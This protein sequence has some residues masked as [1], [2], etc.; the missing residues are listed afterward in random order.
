MTR[1]TTD[2]MTAR[3]AVLPTPE[4]VARKAA[5]LLAEAVSEGLAERGEASLALSGGRTPVPTLEALRRVELDW[6]RVYVTLV[7]ERWVT[8]CSPDSNQ[9]L[10]EEH[11]LVGRACAARFIPMKN[12]ALSPLAGIGRYVQRLHIMPR[13]LDAVLLGMGEDGHFASLFPHS[14]ALRI[15]LDLDSTSTCVASPAGEGGQAPAQ[16]RM[17]LTLAAL[18]KAR[19]IV[20][21]TNGARKLQILERAIRT[22]CNPTDLPIAA[23]LAARPDIAILHGI[24]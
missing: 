22:I 2:L 7:D 12:P 13:P 20:L 15:G 24:Q 11:F 1:L 21:L 17:S 9:R 3:I 8:P 4:A 23:L 6:G 10:L 14:S 19:R 5:G 18:A 16:D